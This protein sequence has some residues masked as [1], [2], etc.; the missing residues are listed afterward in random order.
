MNFYN[1]WK[2]YDYEA[3][4]LYLRSG[5]DAVEELASV[6]TVTTMKREMIVVQVWSEKGSLLSYEASL[7]Q[8]PAST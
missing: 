5:L 1:Y 3:F 4:V 7:E 8:V 6:A 2:T